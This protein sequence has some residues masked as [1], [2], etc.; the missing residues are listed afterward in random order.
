MFEENP[1]LKSFFGSVYFNFLIAA[2]LVFQFFY[3][4]FSYCFSLNYDW[5]GSE[6][7]LNYSYGFIKRAFLGTIVRF[8][9]KNLGFG[10]ENTI[11][12]FMDI[13]MLLFCS[14]IFVF[15]FYLINKY[16]NPAL[17]MLILF[18]ISTDMFGFRFYD[19]GQTDLVL[20][21]LTLLAGFLIWKDRFIWL[22][23]VITIT[24]AL[25]HEGYIMMFFG[26]VVGLLLIRCIQKKSRYYLIVLLITGFITGGLSTFLYFFSKDIILVSP[27]VVTDNA[28]AIFGETLDSY[29][30]Y[31]AL[32]NKGGGLWTDGKPCLDFFIRVTALL[33]AMLLFS[34]LIYFK[35]RFWKTII[36]SEDKK[37]MKF[38]YLM[39]SLLF[40]LTVPLIVFHCD[41]GRWVYDIIF[42]EFFIV[43]FL[44]VLGDEKIRKAL[45][46][47]F[48][49]S[50]ANLYL[51]VILIIVFNHP[52]KQFIDDVCAIP[53][54]LATGGFPY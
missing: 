9:A 44:Y 1:K 2:I 54:F 10:Y 52:N 43:I 53:W 42:V 21:T 41:L 50:R 36:K 11:I 14:V 40:L 48:K 4:G 5:Q 29:M 7:T 37:L 26:L 8:F 18:L 47:I 6:L 25:I 16:K 30:L 19:W 34:G 32:W 23:P 13:E 35:L 33:A 22:V 3:H 27:K 12:A 17:N 15:V 51:I 20:M 38:G 49:T 45:P 24:G 46:L 39:C 28:V 31:Y